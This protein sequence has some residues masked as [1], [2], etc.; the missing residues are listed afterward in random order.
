MSKFNPELLINHTKEVL[1]N[2]IVELND[3]RCKWHRMNKEKRKEI[4]HRAYI[5]RKERLS[6]VAVV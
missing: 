5:K 4:N 2:M 3:K 6:A 1:V